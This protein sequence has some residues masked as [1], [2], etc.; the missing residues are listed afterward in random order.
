[1]FGVHVYGNNKGNNMM[2]YRCEWR[3]SFLEGKARPRFECGEITTSKIA[4]YMYKPC[5]PVVLTKLDKDDI[6]IW[7]GS[8]LFAARSKAERLYEEGM[9]ITRRL[10]DKGVI[11]LWE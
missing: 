5:L 11:L 6:R 8:G 10:K 2:C 1:M 9:I 4:C 7:P 3:A